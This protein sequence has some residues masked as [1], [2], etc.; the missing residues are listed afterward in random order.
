MSGD[1][2]EVRTRQRKL[3][4]VPERADVSSFSIDYIHSLMLH[5]F[6][7]IQSCALYTSSLRNIYFWRL[8]PISQILFED[9][10]NKQCPEKLAENLTCTIYVILSNHPT[11]FHYTC[12][13]L[14]LYSSLMAGFGLVPSGCPV[15][16]AWQCRG[17]R[18]VNVAFVLLISSCRLLYITLCSP[19]TVFALHFI[20]NLL[21]AGISI[22]FWFI[23]AWRSF[24]LQKAIPL[25]LTI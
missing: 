24:I 18:P 20:C 12:T 1:M 2:S 5:F 13:D 7:D 14:Y 8:H 22:F 17:L 23:K 21:F 25:N 4:F 11:L 9:K 3:H 19:S 16:V 10:K 6:P 15:V